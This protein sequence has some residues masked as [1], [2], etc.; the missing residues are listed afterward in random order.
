MGN[1][2]RLCV[3]D[4][5]RMKI[6]SNAFV[7]ANEITDPTNPETTPPTNNPN[8]NGENNDPQ[9]ND[10][11]KVDG[12]QIPNSGNTFFTLG[13]IVKILLGVF[14]LAVIVII[15]MTTKKRRLS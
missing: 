9:N 12:A 14:A 5:C 1:A 15:P 4:I 8:G 3:Y 11:N 2:M 6:A 10:P 7:N 13:N